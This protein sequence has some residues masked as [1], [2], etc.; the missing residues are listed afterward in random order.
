MNTGKFQSLEQKLQ[1]YSN[2]VEM[3]RHAKVGGYAFPFPGEYTNWRDEQEAWTKSVVIFDQSFHMTDVYFEGPD[4]KRLISDLGV[5]TMKNFGANKAKQLVT[6]TP[7]GNVIG[8]AILFGHTDEKI[9]VVGRPSVPNWVDFNARTGNYDVEITRDE[10]TVSNAADRLIYR[11]QIQGPN[12][13]D[14]IA[15]ASGSPLPDIKFF[16]LGDIK[17]AGKNVRALNHSMSRSKGLELHGPI[18]DREAVLEAILAVGEEFGLRRGGSRSYSTV[19]PESGWIPSPMPAIYSGDSMKPYR[20]WLSA[21]GFEAN[22]S[23]GGSFYSSNIEDYYQTPWDL[24]YGRHVKFD[25]DFIGREALEKKAEMPHR[26][27]VWLQW[28]DEDVMRVFASQLGDGDRF[29]YM[30]TPNAYYSILPFDKI[31]LG[32]QMVGLSTYTVFT[33]N[34]RHWFS[35][36]M[37]DEAVVEDGKE[38]RVVWGEEDGGSNKPIVEPHVQT[39]IRATISTKRLNER[40]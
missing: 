26:Q 5:N 19:S 2:P 14:L 9:S 35:L 6:C 24:G 40:S 29:K 23:L 25:H 39:E 15:K 11:Y 22:A 36:A 38:V 17:I 31:L 30:E 10:R 3:L 4:V 8:D 37:V 20:E 27:K 18:E 12:A 13:L 28:N 1:N 21:S 34:V 33:A 16:N 32:D 7:E